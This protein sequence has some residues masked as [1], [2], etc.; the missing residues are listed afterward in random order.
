MCDDWKNEKNNS[1]HTKQQVE[2]THRGPRGP[3]P[4]VGVSYNTH[5]HES[6]LQITTRSQIPNQPTTTTTVPTNHTSPYQSY[7]RA[8]TAA[9]H[10]HARTAQISLRVR[11]QGAG[12]AGVTPQSG[13]IL[14]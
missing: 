12:A 1:A 13:G 5:T 11:E 9:D 2:S 7:S 3:S 14:L 10:T 8:G 4:L 6:I